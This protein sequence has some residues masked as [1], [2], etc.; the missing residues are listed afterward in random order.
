MGLGGAEGSFE[1]QRPH[2]GFGL[3]GLQS[4]QGRKL[5]HWGQIPLQGVGGVGE[6]GISVADFDASLVIRVSSQSSSP[7]ASQGALLPPPP[8]AGL[9]LPRALSFTDLRGRRVEP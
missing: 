5:E 9:L 6:G 7:W 8:I 1:Y 4:L 2:P 3:C